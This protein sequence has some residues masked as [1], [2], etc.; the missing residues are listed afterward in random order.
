MPAKLRALYLTIWAGVEPPHGVT[1]KLYYLDSVFPRSK[2][3]AA[4][5]WLVRN[6]IVGQKFVD[7]Y[8]ND[9]MG[10]SLEMQRK[11]IQIVE[12]EKHSRVLYAAKDLQGG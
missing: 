4:L 6:K 3:E 2:L 8:D 12:R 9:C 5:K 11:L 1:T 10:S 7:W